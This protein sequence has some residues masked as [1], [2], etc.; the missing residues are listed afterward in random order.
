[1]SFE[2]SLPF[3]FEGLRVLWV[4]EGDVIDCPTLRFTLL[5]KMAR[6]K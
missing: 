2:G 4:I 1:M 6:Q 5:G 3:A